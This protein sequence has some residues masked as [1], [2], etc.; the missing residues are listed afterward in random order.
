[1]NEQFMSELGVVRKT[2]ELEQRYLSLKAG[3]A[4]ES[5]GDHRRIG[6]DL[7]KITIGDFRSPEYFRS[8]LKSLVGYQKAT[9]YLDHVS[10]TKGLYS[11]VVIPD[12]T[13]N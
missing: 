2:P 5:V 8:K 1:M 9:C 7:F 13:N 4:W 6:R 11:V 10:P 3:R 12:R